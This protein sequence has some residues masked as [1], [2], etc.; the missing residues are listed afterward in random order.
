MRCKQNFLIFCTVLFVLLKNA[1]HAKKTKVPQITELE[2]VW[3]LHNN[4]CL[5]RKTVKLIHLDC[6]FAIRAYYQSLKKEISTKYRGN[7]HVH[8]RAVERHCYLNDFH[9]KCNKQPKT[10]IW[11]TLYETFNINK[12]WKQNIVWIN[13]HVSDKTSRTRSKMTQM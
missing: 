11:V 8:Q 4:S 5:C 13:L 3:Y 6:V 9:R 7:I 1:L 2:R 10:T 12:H